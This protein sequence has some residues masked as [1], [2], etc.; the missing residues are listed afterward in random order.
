M[1]RRKR[2]LGIGIFVILAAVLG[3]GMYLRIR[4]HGSN[5]AAA[6]SPGGEAPDVSAS[7]AFATDVAIPVSGAPVIRDTLV[8]RVTASGQA[9]AWRQ[10]V[11]TAQVKGRVVRLPVR[12]NQN[13]RSG[14]LLLALDST[15]YGL[16]VE[17]AAAQLRRVQAEYQ[18]L[19][20]FD[21]RTIQDSVVRAERE[22]N[23]RAKSGLDAA[24]V[25]L[26]RARFELQQ[27]RVRAPFPG[28][29]A[30]V[31]VVVG[32]MANAGTDLLTV[33]DLDSI[34]VE[35][36]VLEGEVGYLTPGRRAQVRF[37]AFPDEVFEGRV[38]TVNPM[39]DEQTRTAKV[40]VTVPNPDGRILPGMYARVSLDAQR[41]PDRILVPRSAILE[42][43]R[44][45]MLFVYED[46]YAKWRYVT[47]GL[48]NEDYVEI[49]PN[50]DTEMVKPGEIVLTDGHYTLIHDARVRLV[51]DVK[52]AGGRPN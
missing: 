50:S 3:T 12:E 14:A 42:R 22:K 33:V 21:S 25:A 35:V 18:A 38:A 37:S 27:T 29:V 2:L 49:V 52:A 34:K 23:A 40:T 47:T 10:A 13:V 1:A 41:L 6:E 39:V 51:D 4:G 48:E 9:A 32:Q 36:Q 11:L 43:D 28:R 30:S 46:G 20:L 24:E 31:N 17:D 45:T 7:S 5:E 8:L 19:T 16:N 44:R 15:E 26:R